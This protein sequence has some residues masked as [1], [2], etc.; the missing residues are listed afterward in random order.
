MQGSSFT[1]TRIDFKK[2]F[3]FQLPEPRRTTLYVT[4]IQIKMFT[5]CLLSL[6]KID[7][8]LILFNTFHQHLF[9]KR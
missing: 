2:Y 5:S 4:E 7:I 9:Q 3:H 6:K 8:Q 1:H